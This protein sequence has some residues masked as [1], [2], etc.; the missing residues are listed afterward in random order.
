MLGPASAAPKQGRPV[1]G[2]NWRLMR[3]G[4]AIGRRLQTGRQGGA[5][6][7]GFDVGAQSRDDPQNGQCGSCL[8]SRRAS[9][10]RSVAIECGLCRSGR[11]RRPAWAELRRRPGGNESKM[12]GAGGGGK[13]VPLG[14]QEPISRD[15]QRGVMVEPT[16]VAAFEVPQPQLLFQLL[17]VPLDDPAVFGQLDQSFEFGRGRQR[18]SWRKARGGGDRACPAGSEWDDCGRPLLGVGGGPPDP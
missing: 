7:V 11:T 13:T 8:S 3:R 6:G 1:P 15:T 16:P 17:V 4:R 9:A 14:H 18:L 10:M 5:G 12:T 2:G